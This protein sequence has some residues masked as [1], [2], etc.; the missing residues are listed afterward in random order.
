[1]VDGFGEEVSVVVVTAADVFTS[2]TTPQP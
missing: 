2:N 1:L